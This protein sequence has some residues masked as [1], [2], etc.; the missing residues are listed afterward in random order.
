M[1]A[2][3]A[4]TG[5]RP[6][7]VLYYSG[8]LEPFQASF[9]TAAAAHGAVPL[10]QLDP[11]DVSIAAIAS[12]QYDSFPDP[13]AE[14]VRAYRHP[15][16]LSF[17]HEMNG[18][19]YSWGYRHTPPAVFVAAWRHIVTLFRTAGARNV[20]W[21]WTINIIHPAGQRSLLPARAPGGP[22]ARM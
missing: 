9:A 18:I 10:V 12:G 22:A 8:W 3:T 2:F 11:K 1:T 14:A 20:T 15:V 5:V 16:I 13:Y 6:N 4:A 7:I 21:M 19:W 17:G